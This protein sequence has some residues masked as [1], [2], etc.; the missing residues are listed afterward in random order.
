MPSHL[1]PHP[2][3]RTALVQAILASVLLAGACD[4]GADD[5]GDDDG[6]EEFFFFKLESP[7]VGGD[8]F[9]LRFT[10]PFVAGGRQTMTVYK[11]YEPSLDSS[12]LLDPFILELEGQEW[13]VADVT[14]PTVEIR[15]GDGD[16]SLR[17]LGSAGETLGE[18]SSDSRTLRAEAIASVA[19]GPYLERRESRSWAFFVG[20]PR[21]LYVEMLDADRQPLVDEDVELDAPG[22]GQRLAWDVV[23]VSSE[24]TGETGVAVTASDGVERSVSVQWVDA[25]DEVHPIETPLTTAVGENVAACFGARAGDLSVHGLTWSFESTGPIEVTYEPSTAPSIRFVGRNCATVEGIAVGQGTLT[26][27]AAGR[28]VTVDVLVDPSDQG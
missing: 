26:A 11:V 7:A 27:R 19:G 23:E 6:G 2:R 1:V 20:G 21:P 14:P 9:G 12:P 13:A 24:S 8:Q 10:R 15:A 25:I 18:V 28:E 3:P 22:G 16:A 17:L 4:S 5:D